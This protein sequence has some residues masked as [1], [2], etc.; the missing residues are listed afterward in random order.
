[1]SIRAHADQHD[2][3]TASL[4]RFIEEHDSADLGIRLC[5]MI[6]AVATAANSAMQRL[7][8]RYR[9]RAAILVHGY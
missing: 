2:A 7:N 1:M 5:M 8:L 9:L 6:I 4:S 3:I